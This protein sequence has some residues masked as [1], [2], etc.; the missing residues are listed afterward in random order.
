MAN[1]VVALMRHLGHE[2]FAVVGH[3]RGSL[4]AFRTAMDH[5][6]VVTRLVVMDG[7]PVVEH[8]E[9]LNETFVRT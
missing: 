5:P 9:P 6:H 2:R 4:V 1:D 7:L 3:D 8:L